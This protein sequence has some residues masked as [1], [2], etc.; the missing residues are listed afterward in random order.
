MPKRSTP[1][2]ALAWGA[3]VLV[4]ALAWLGS[5][6]VRAKLAE[7][8]ASREVVRDDDAFYRAHAVLGPE[9]PLFEAVRERLAAGTPIAVTGTGVEGTAR[10]QRFWL[11]LLP[12]YP[13]SDG[14]ATEICPRAC[15]D[16]AS[17]VLAEG[18]DFVWIRRAPS[19]P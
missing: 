13:V 1:A 3:W 8:R 16:R 15:L 6:P 2:S 10:R 14:A 11:T 12:Q 19:Q 5:G 18:R 17:E 4:L 9:M 7:A